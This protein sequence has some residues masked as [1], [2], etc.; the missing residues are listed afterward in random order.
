[1]EKSNRSFCSVCKLFILFLA[2][3]AAYYLIEVL[4]RGH[5][6]PSMFV[7]GGICFVL[8]GEIN[9]R[10]RRNMSMLKQQLISMLIITVLEFIFGVVLNLWLGLNIWDYSALPFNLMGQICLPFMVVWFFLS[11]V[12]I[13]ADDQLRHLLFGEEKP[14]YVLV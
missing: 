9:E 6:Y 10:C 12:A 11:A 3:G 5:S 14:H 1:M 2:G 4:Y 7:L 8:C 13:V